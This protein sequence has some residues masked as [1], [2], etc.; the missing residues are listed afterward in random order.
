MNT[1]LSGRLVRAVRPTRDSSPGQ[2]AGTHCARC[3][4]A[5]APGEQTSALDRP[6]KAR[7]LRVCAEGCILDVVDAV[8]ELFAA[9]VP[10]A[11]LCYLGLDDDPYDPAHPDPYYLARQQCAE[12]TVADG[13]KSVGTGLLPLPY[14][15]AIAAQARALGMTAEIGPA[16]EQHP[17][18]VWVQI[19]RRLPAEDE[20]AAIGRAD[21]VIGERFGTTDFTELGSDG[22]TAWYRAAIEAVPGWTERAR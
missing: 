10:G 3:A 2:L 11:L 6:R 4:R 21:T 7:G 14:A 19:S 20:F 1:L 5:F 18:D 8:A 12:V 13:A 15:Q 22:R 16:S 17:F 9:K